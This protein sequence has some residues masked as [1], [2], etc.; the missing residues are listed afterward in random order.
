MGKLQGD[1]K[2]SVEIKTLT[3]DKVMCMCTNVRSI[4]NKNK[5]RNRTNY[6]GKGGRYF[7]NY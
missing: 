6:K 3:R 7:G 1:K 5:R 2:K 4:M